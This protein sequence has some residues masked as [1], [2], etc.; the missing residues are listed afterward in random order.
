MGKASILNSQA[1][2]EL[3]I[4]G[5]LDHQFSYKNE[6]SF[7]EK[8]NSEIPELNHANVNLP[9]PDLQKL[10]NK[11]SILQDQIASLQ[12]ETQTNKVTSLKQLDSTITIDQLWDYLQSHNDLKKDLLKKVNV[13]QAFPVRLHLSGA[14]IGTKYVNEEIVRRYGLSDG[15]LANANFE[16]SKIT[17]NVIKHNGHTLDDAGIKF[18]TGEIVDR[19]GHLEVDNPTGDGNISGTAAF[20]MGALPYV[21]TH[22]EIDKYDLKVGQI[23]DVSW[24]ASNPGTIKIVWIHP[25]EAADSQAESKPEKPKKPTGNTPKP[26]TPNYAEIKPI[27]SGKTV[28]LVGDSVYTENLRRVTDAYDA[29]LT[30][31]DS[32]DRE[33]FEAMVESADMLIIALHYVSHRDSNLAVDLAKAHGLT[34]ATF[35][36]HAK[37]PFEIAL[38]T[39]AQRYEAAQVN[40]EE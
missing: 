30:E 23:V 7:T 26:W 24:Y 17:V 10:L 21:P 34:Y 39:A 33:R 9:Y 28:L 35:N 4:M 22:E 11:I 29:T 1:K 25:E 13:A 8:T 36:Q 6:P 32:I 15:D 5:L 14:N 20:E 16:D 19:N 40:A 18:Y 27:V 12:Q 38:R 37:I 3:S 31:V 2:E